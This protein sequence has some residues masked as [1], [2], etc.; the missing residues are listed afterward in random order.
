[1]ARMMCVPAPRRKSPAVFVA[2][3]VQTVGSSCVLNRIRSGSCAGLILPSLLMKLFAPKAI[4]WRSLSETMICV[5]IVGQEGSVDRESSSTPRTPVP[6]V[7]QRI[8]ITLG[9]MVL[10][11][12]EIILEE[13]VTQMA[14]IG[15]VL[16]AI[17]II[18]VQFML[19]VI[20]KI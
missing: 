10:V 12:M 6:V 1:M 4:T 20:F 3:G 14:R 5:A 18:T 11:G 9:G 7:Q 16:V 2:D 15:R 13:V 19:V 8:V 17:I